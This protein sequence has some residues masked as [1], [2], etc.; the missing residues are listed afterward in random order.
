[1]KNAVAVSIIL[2]AVMLLFP[3][4]SLKSNGSEAKNVSVQNLTGADDFTDKIIN[5]DRKTFKIKDKD[6]GEITEMNA[7]DYIRGVVSAEMPALYEEEALK[8]QAVAAYS[9]ACYKKER[10]TGDFDL[11]TDPAFYQSYVS[12][13]KAK[14]NWGSKAEEY[15]EKINSA[16]EEVSG[17]RLTYNGKTALCAYHAIS[18]GK[19]ENCKEVWGGD[20]PY[21]TS[22]DSIGDKL[23]DDYISTVTF[24]PEKII[25]KLSLSGENKT[26]IF[27]NFKRLKTGRV[28]TVD[29]DSKELSGAEVAKKLGLRSSNFEVSYKKNKYCFTVKGFGHGVGMSQNGAQYMAK[30]GSG[31]EE[32]LLHYYPGCKIAD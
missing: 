1:M 14:K 7:N 10:S 22:V 16:V 23:C 19:T 31:Y 28:K 29:C 27:K 9:F 13:E 12:D 24:S 30:Q 6:T 11:T 17:K 2:I 5:T 21:L 18:S 8:A 4:F 32:I 15:L 25:S 26:G 20:L 3:L